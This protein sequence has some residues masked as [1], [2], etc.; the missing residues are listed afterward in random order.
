MA[1][2]GSPVLRRC[3]GMSGH[4][5][6]LNP[7]GQGL[8]DARAHSRKQRDLLKPHRFRKS[9]QQVH[10]LHSLTGRAFHQIVERRADDGAAFDP[11]VGTPRYR[12]C[13]SRARGW[14]AAFGR[15]AGR[16]RTAPRG[17]RR[18]PGERPSKTS[19]AR[20]SLWHIMQE[21]WRLLLV[22][23]LRCHATMELSLQFCEAQREPVQMA[24]PHCK[25]TQNDRVQSCESGE[26]F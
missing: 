8:A 16:A 1:L 10:V 15:T 26:G 9:E 18:R 11:I 22:T 19:W 17:R 21:D 14:S 5:A 6:R 2:L 12:S 20:R 24:E 3:R 13:S 7:L 4:E 25:E 23:T